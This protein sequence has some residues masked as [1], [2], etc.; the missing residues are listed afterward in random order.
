MGYGI[1]YTRWPSFTSVHLRPTYCC[2]IYFVLLHPRIIW[3][4]SYICPN[5]SGVGRSRIDLYPS[6]SNTI[7][8]SRSKLAFDRWVHP[9]H[10]LTR[11]TVASVRLMYSRTFSKDRHVPEHWV[12]LAILNKY[13]D[14][15]IYVHIDI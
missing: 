2:N 7:G 4:P 10:Q 15:I 5:V 12:G 14:S 3:Q 13:M 8:F 11:Y 6:M 1:C 9:I